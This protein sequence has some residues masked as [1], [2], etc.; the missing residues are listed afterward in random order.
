MTKNTESEYVFSQLKHPS[1]RKAITEQ[2]HFAIIGGSLKPG[3]RI[4]EQLICEQLGVSR[5]SVREAF[6]EMRAMGVL[7]ENRRKTYI[8][9]GPGPDE[10]RDTFAL[11]GL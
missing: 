1:L 5:T 6:Q 3:Q 4:T 7:T 2:I 11:R 9:S 8:S 10:I